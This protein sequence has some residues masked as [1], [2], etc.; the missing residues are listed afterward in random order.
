MSDN[1]SIYVIMNLSQCITLP[2]TTVQVNSPGP[3]S[4]K[5]AQGKQGLITEKDVAKNRLLH[6]SSYTH[7]LFVTGNYQ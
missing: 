6:I 7:K 2:V 4:I 1:V 5:H 3:V